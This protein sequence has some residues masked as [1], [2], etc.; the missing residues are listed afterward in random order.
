MD[1]ADWT[2]QPVATQTLGAAGGGTVAAVLAFRQTAALHRVLRGG[3]PRCLGCDQQ[4]T[5]EVD[6]VRTVCIAIGTRCPSQILAVARPRT[7]SCDGG[8]RRRWRSAI[9]PS[10]PRDPVRPAWRRTSARLIGRVLIVGAP[11]EMT[12]AKRVSN[13][14]CRRRPS[15]RGVPSAARTTSGHARTST[16]PDRT[17]AT[18]PA[19][20]GPGRVFGIRRLP[21]RRHG[22]ARAGRWHAASAATR[23]RSPSR[24]HDAAHRSSMS[25]PLTESRTSGYWP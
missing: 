20:S 12:A 16:R 4:G 15:R 25:R 22:G 6:Q 3:A 18:S 2:E 19:P 9:A 10:A 7:S 24:R 8:S 5:Y 14:S 13:S 23:A 1:G 17:P 21:P 11:A